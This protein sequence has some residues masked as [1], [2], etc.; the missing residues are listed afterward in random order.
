[1]D[2]TL[3]RL[4]DAISQI[5]DHNASQLSFE[6]HYRYAYNLVLHKKVRRLTFP[7]FAI[8]TWHADIFETHQGHL[9][10]NAVAELIAN[11]LESET[12][13]K[14]VPAFP[15]SSSVTS[16]SAAAAIAGSSTG[17]GPSG[18]GGV[19][20]TNEDVSRAAEGQLFLDRLRDVW[21]DH[22]ACMSKLKDVLKYLV[23]ATLESRCKLSVTE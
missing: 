11:H 13:S 4:K 20:G 7:S 3:D 5:H 12:K 19:A 14:I 6:E 1:M 10:Y 17:G 8:R 18:S 16:S 2:H 15:H 23:S 22:T 21:E 9:L